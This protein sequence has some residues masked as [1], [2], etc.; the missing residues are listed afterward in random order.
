MTKSIPRRGRNKPLVPFGILAGAGLMATATLAAV[1]PPM[2]QDELAPGNAIEV[3]KTVDVPAFPPKLDV[4]V[5]F[6]LSGSFNTDIMFIQAN[7]L[8]QG[9]VDGV[10]AEVADS[11]FALASHVDYPF[12]QWGFP[13]SG[14]YAYLLNQAMTANAPAWVTAVNALTTFS[15]FDGPE[16][17]Y[18]A[19]FQAVTGAG[20]DVGE[21]G[22]SEGDI[23]PGMACD[24]REDATKVIVHSTDA[25][26]HTPDDS[27]CV[28]PAPPCPFGYPG[29]SR[30]D[31]LTALLDAGITYI[32]LDPTLTPMGGGI[33]EVQDLADE[34]GGSVQPLEDD[35]ENIVTA[36]LDALEELTFDISGRPNACEPLN[37]TFDP[38]VIPDVVGP[39][40]VQFT[41]QIEVPADVTKDDLPADRVVHCEVDFLADDAP[42]ATQTVWI[43]VQLARLLVADE[44][45]TDIED[46]PLPI[47]AILTL[48]TG[49]DDEPGFYLPP[50]PAPFDVAGFIEGT[51]P[52]NVLKRV[53]GVDPVD[54]PAKV[55]DL[56]GDTFCVVVLD[57]VESRRGLTDLSERE[58]VTAFE[59]IAVL[60]GGD[61]EDLPSIEVQVVDPVETC[62]ILGADLTG[63]PLGDDDD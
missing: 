25:P 18:E 3:L 8:A 11:R 32:G 57:E 12:E 54:T 37:I 36:I 42:I 53:P 20:R 31:V 33:A 62:A 22:P 44:D 61:D 47:G 60:G 2:V 48:S 23:E 51:L 19:I 52:K 27:L 4:C 10:R 56:L 40:T 43:E 49:E 16:S 13:P 38:A 24:F 59:V 29:P 39:T 21:D 46:L 9:I 6:D 7:N 30:D 58:G 41:E 34:T 50:V 45:E 14:D 26:F 63:V 35:S 17:Q 5:I 1:D 55:D 15:G 28:S